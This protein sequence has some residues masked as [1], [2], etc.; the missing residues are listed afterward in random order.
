MIKFLLLILLAISITTSINIH[1]AKIYVWHNE[2]GEVVYSDTPKAG[3]EEVTTNPGYIVQSS[4]SI[5]TQTLDIQ[6][7]I[8]PED[9]QVIINQPK[10]DATIRDN[11]GSLFISAVIQPIFKRGLTA[12]LILDGKPHQERQNHTRFSLR[13]IDRGEHKIK[14]QIFN[15]KGKVIALSKPVTFYMHRASVH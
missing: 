12:Q 3:A 10:N 5:E 7:K 1:A 11:T 6:K 14:V 8:I 2:I 9:Y 4:T 15:E 13:N